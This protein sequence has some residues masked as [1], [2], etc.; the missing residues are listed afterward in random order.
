MKFFLR[1]FAVWLLLDCAQVAW[2][3][4]AGL[5]IDRVDVKFVGPA[6]VSEQFVRVNIRVS[7]GETYKLSSTQDDVHALYATGQFYNIRVSVDQSTNSGVVLTYV[8]QARPRVTE[9]KIAG[10][11]KVSDSKIKKKITVKVGDPLDEQKLFT[12]VQEI[13]KLYE[14][15]GYAD[16]QVKYVTSVDENAGHGTVTFEIVESRKVKITE[17]DF[18]GAAAFSQKELRKVIKLKRHW[19]WSWLTGS[20]V[21]KQDEF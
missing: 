17:I 7:T 2:S 10:N 18:L 16:T 3:Q 11:K 4:T 8:V 5:K 1:L 12:D 6:T 19:M 13:K 9:I 21:F 14:K 15:Y 20:G